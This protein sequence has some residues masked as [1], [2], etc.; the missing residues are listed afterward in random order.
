[1][2]R[3]KARVRET[4]SRYDTADYLKSEDDIAA[5][6]QAVMED[7]GDDARLIAA[8]LGDVARA[9]GMMQLARDTGLTREGLYKALSADGNPS[10]DTVLRVMKALGLRLQPRR[11]AEAPV[12]RRKRRVA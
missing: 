12:R 4:F 7:G 2:A 8:A 5:Y 10:L 9:R 6:L 1:M 3:K 11:I